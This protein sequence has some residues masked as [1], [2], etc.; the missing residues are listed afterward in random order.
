M[1]KSTISMAMFHCY[2]GSPEGK[3][4]NWQNK[5][6]CVSGGDKPAF[7]SG[8]GFFIELHYAPR[9]SPA[10]KKHINPGFMRSTW[11][12]HQV[13]YC[14]WSYF[15]PILPSLVIMA[16]WKTLHS[17]WG[18]F[19][20]KKMRILARRLETH[21]WRCTCV[22]RCNC[23]YIFLV[24]IYV[25]YALSQWHIYMYMYLVYAIY[26]YVY[27]CLSWHVYI[28]IHLCMCVI[29]VCRLRTYLHAL[30]KINY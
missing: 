8:G 10:K 6:P 22:I 23:L 3:W 16:S 19:S 18:R 9:A 25:L 12:T 21:D 4:E 20:R 5:Q 2:V 7:H 30:S 1:G 17:S 27:I 28:Y 26:A 13:C 24:S 11:V 29:Y 14:W 15:L